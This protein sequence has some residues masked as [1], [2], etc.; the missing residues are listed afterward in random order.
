[1]LAFGGDGDGEDAVAAAEVEDYICAAAPLEVGG[2]GQKV[3]IPEGCGS[4]R[5]TTRVV[6]CGT[7]GATVV[8]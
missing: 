4:R 8:E 6:S 7:K 2:K 5:E 1:V 3:G